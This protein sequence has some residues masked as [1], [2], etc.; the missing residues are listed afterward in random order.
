MFGW[1]SLAAVLAS[2]RK[3]STVSGSAASAGLRTFSATSS[4]SSGSSARYTRAKPPPPT[5]P[6]M[7]YR[8]IS[9]PST[10][11]PSSGVTGTTGAA[12]GE[13]GVRESSKRGAGWRLGRSAEADAA[14]SRASAGSAADA[15]APPPSLYSLLR[16]Q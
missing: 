14:A 1:R 9:R 6:R 15:A 3:R 5:I 10:R 16:F 11:S 12:W 7:R 8:P 13:S 4:S 2:R